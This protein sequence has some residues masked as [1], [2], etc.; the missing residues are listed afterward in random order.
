MERLATFFDTSSTK[1]GNQNE[2]LLIRGLNRVEGRA[3]LQHKARY[4][5]GTIADIK[6]HYLPVE[7][8]RRKL[9]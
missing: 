3:G 7:A 1:L 2:H 9:H 4:F 8:Y 6:V 5:R